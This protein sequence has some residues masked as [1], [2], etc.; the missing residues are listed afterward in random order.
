MGGERASSVAA[1]GLG[2]KENTNKIS[3]YVSGLGLLERF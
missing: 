2:K 1:K 3:I